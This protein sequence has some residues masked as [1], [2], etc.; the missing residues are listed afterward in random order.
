MN[1]QRINR[2]R[3]IENHLIG[4][5]ET[6]IRIIDLSGSILSSYFVDKNNGSIT[7]IHVDGEHLFIIT[8]NKQLVLFDVLQQKKIGNYFN[9]FTQFAKDKLPD[10]KTLTCITTGNDG[11]FLAL[12]GATGSLYIVR[13]WIIAHTTLFC[14]I[15]NLL[16][17]FIFLTVSTL[18]PHRSFSFLF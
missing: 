15:F 5:S 9:D 3:F 13:S 16:I 7:D 1:S 4:A 18:N 14:M 17:I 2:L 6:E 12:G 8:S 10:E 11:L